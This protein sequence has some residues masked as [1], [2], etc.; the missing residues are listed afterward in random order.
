[1]SATVEVESGVEKTPQY[2]E[3]EQ[4]FR[5]GAKS[6]E[7]PY[8]TGDKRTRWMSGYYYERVR[9]LLEK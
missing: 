8:A 5:A 1:M 7:C 9:P 4:A 6:E 2:A 3:G